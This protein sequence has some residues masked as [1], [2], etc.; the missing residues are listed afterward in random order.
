MMF[1]M[2][3]FGHLGITLGIFFILSQFIPSI[4]SR[5]DYRIIALGAL[6]PDLVDKPIGRFLFAE[7]VASGRLVGHTLVFVLIL[8]IGGYVLLKQR[9]D[10]L[11]VQVAG[12]GFLHLV[13]D[14]MWMSPVTLLWPA[15][16]WKF[17]QG[18]A[19]GSF[20]DYL[21]DV[22]SHCYVPEPSYEFV[23][24]VVGFIVLTGML[25]RYVRRHRDVHVV[26]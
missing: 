12:A 14:R 25:V 3:I 13:E 20:K 2:F 19:Y 22:I 8:L 5:L 15:L 18:D 26:K 24:E 21:L 7:S 6:L 17:P 4:R 1:T 23:S 10:S 11:G 9:R 16:G